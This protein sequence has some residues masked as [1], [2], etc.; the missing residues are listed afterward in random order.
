MNVTTLYI[1][2][3]RMK[4]IPPSFKVLIKQENWASWYGFNLGGKHE[5]L[6]LK[7]REDTREAIV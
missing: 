4:P 3:S 2:V 1:A 5:R 7:I 6:T